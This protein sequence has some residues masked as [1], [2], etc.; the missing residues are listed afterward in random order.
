MGEKEKESTRTKTIPEVIR[1]LQGIVKPGY[2]GYEAIIKS[3]DILDAFND[4]ATVAYS[5]PLKEY[6]LLE[7]EV[8]DPDIIVPE[9]EG[10]MKIYKG[11]PVEG[12]IKSAIKD[13]KEGKIPEKIL[14]EVQQE[15]KQEEQKEPG[16]EPVD[17]EE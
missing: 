17:K 6:A 16:K 15:K 9:L 13:I 7:K 12:E 2:E 10:I 5:K 4:E 8:Q 14:K 3:Y 11:L 1:I